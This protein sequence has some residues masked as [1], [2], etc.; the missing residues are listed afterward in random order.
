MR[1]FY[2]RLID[3][4]DREWFFNQIRLSVS[5]NFQE[6]FDVVFNNLSDSSVCNF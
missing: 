6:V 4:I 2:D 1:V 3:Y 5:N